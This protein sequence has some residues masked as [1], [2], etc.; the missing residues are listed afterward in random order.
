MPAIDTLNK[1]YA[2][3]KRTNKHAQKY[4]A[5][6]ASRVKQGRLKYVL[7]GILALIVGASASALTSSMTA[8]KTAQPSLSQNNQPTVIQTAPTTQPTPVQSNTN[9]ASTVSPTH[10][11]AN[12]SCTNVVIPYGTTYQYVATLNQGQRETI[13][14]TNGYKLE[15]PGEPTQTFNPANQIIYIGTYVAP[16]LPPSSGSMSSS[17]LQAQ[18]KQQ[19]LNSCIQYLQQIAPDSSAYMQCYSLY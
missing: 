14:G 6:W 11:T 18:E 4:L 13:P 15:C 16:T 8:K 5:K 10:S 3:A 19:E 9:H 1:V 17:D 7:L 2:M 12:I